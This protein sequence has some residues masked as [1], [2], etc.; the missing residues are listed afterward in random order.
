MHQLSP[1]AGPHRG[2]GNRQATRLAVWGI[3]QEQVIKCRLAKGPEVTFKKTD[4][5]RNSTWQNSPPSSPTGTLSSTLVFYVFY[6]SL[7][8]DTLPCSQLSLHSTYPQDHLTA[9]GLISK[10]ALQSLVSCE[11]RYN[12]DTERET[13]TDER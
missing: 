13:E 2:N 4:L 12:R 10:G 1:R 7:Q 3:E 6:V 11:R 8:Q 5:E 9:S